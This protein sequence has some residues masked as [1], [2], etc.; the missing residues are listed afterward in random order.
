MEAKLE[1]H[2]VHLGE[3]RHDLYTYG[4]S[5]LQLF[6][7]KNNC[8]K[9]FSKMTEFGRE[10]RGKGIDYSQINFKVEVT[11]LISLKK[12][13]HIGLEDNKNKVSSTGLTRFELRWLVMIQEI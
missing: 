12:T 11:I 1:L 2:Q 9:S 7:E 10:K 13:W 4:F 8:K 5:L 6:E 3:Q